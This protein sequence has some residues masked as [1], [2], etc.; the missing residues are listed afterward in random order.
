[1]QITKMGSMSELYPINAIP[2]MSLSISG[3]TWAGLSLPLHESILMTAIPSHFITTGMKKQT[4]YRN[5]SGSWLYL[6]V[7]PTYPGKTFQ[8]DPLLR[9]L[10]QTP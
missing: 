7:N 6:P 8:N 3:V 9:D 2:I 5:H 1:M 10:C 4:H